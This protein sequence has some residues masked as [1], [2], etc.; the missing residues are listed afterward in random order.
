MQYL[1]DD[2]S[3]GG[4]VMNNTAH[5]LHEE[6]SRLLRDYK[7]VY[8]YVRTNNDWKNPFRDLIGKEIPNLLRQSTN[9]APPYHIVGSY[10]KGRWTAVPW[11]AVFDSRITTS[12]QKGV[13]IVYLLNK[14]TQELYLTFEIAATEAM[15]IRQNPVLNFL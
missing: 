5:K 6:F 9:I 1:Q 7:Q 8:D 3:L 2:I 12:A 14:D 11:I 4:G 15:N 13:Y 10:G